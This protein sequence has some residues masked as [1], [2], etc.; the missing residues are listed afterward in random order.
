MKQFSCK[1]EN[2][3]NGD[4]WYA[5]YA[6]NDDQES[7]IVLKSHVLL[8]ITYD[9]PSKKQPSSHLVVFQKILF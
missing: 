4:L 2:L 6:V 1:T 5:F 3:Q 7:I 9:H 8:I